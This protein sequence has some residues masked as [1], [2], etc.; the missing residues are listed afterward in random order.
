MPVAAC[1]HMIETPGSARPC[2]PATGGE[3][4]LTAEQAL[5]GVLYHRVPDVSCWAKLWDKALFDGLRY[6]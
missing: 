2:F 4:V 5:E 1:N 6:P 3:Q